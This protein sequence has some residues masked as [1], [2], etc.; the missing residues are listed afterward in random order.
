M[1]NNYLEKILK[2]ISLFILLSF[3]AG[4]F[5]WNMYLNQFGFIENSLIQTRFILTGAMFFGVHIFRV[6]PLFIKQDYLILLVPILT[7]AVYYIVYYSK[8]SSRWL[9]KLRSKKDKF[10]YGLFSVSI[11]LS[12]IV[13]LLYLLKFYA[14]NIFPFI[15]LYTGGAAPRVVSLLTDEKQIEYFQNFNI[16]VSSNS[17]TKK[18]VQTANLC[19]GYEND[20]SILLLLPDRIL[21]VQ[22]KYIK[23]IGSIP[24]DFTDQY[25]DKVCKAILTSWLY[26]LQTPNQ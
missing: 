23:G 10:F 7:F 3:A 6:I 14:L 1:K 15:P 4:F 22:K 5:I 20:E 16:P 26:K 8:L 12:A 19:V 9:L 17:G 18:P 25:N 11:Y 21:S 24:T 2:T 13:V